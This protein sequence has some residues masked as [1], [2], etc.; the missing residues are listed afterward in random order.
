MQPCDVSREIVEAVAACSASSVKV[1]AVQTLHDVNVVGNFKIGNN[2]LAE[3]LYLNVLAVVLADGN[4]GVDDVRDDHHSLFDLFLQLALLHLEL[5][6]LFAEEL[7]LSLYLLGFLF[8]ALGHKAADLFREC[9]SLCA[10]FVALGLGCAE[11][12]IESN[13]L[14]DEGQLI[15]LE[16]LLYIFFDELRLGTEKFDVKHS[17][18]SLVK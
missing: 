4:G 18:L 9:V 14:I 17:N 10:V 5:G 11:F 3:T 12:L 6:Q 7:D 2:R 8:Q 16:F 15:V 13:D 1:D